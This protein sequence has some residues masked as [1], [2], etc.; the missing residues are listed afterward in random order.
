MEKPTEDF[1]GKKGYL[2]RVTLRQKLREAPPRFPDSARKYTR[3]EREEFEKKFD[4]KKYG[5]NISRKDVKGLI[6]GLE[7]KKVWTNWQE[8][9]QINNDIDYLKK[10]G[11]FK[12]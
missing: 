10:L 12:S 6:K 9:K 11:D 8:R 5:P 2:P 3:R 1:F 7:K 4:F